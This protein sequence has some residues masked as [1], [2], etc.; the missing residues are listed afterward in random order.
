M[1]WWCLTRL[2]QDSAD[3]PQI[4]PLGKTR[5]DGVSILTTKS[6]VLAL[7]CH[8]IATSNNRPFLPHSAFYI[9]SNLASSQNREDRE[10]PTN[11]FTMALWTFQKFFTQ[12]KLQFYLCISSNQCAH[13]PSEVMTDAVIAVMD[14]LT[15][16][17]WQEA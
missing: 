8:S 17:N 5:W 4:T 11:K 12:L 14:D 15:E 6:Y 2:N 1:T 13:W 3:K 10:L 7:L 9:L 16:A